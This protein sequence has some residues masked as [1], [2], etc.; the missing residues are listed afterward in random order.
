MF[1]KFIAGLALVTGIVGIGMGIGTAGASAATCPADM[2]WTA[3]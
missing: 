2:H 3:C 1:R